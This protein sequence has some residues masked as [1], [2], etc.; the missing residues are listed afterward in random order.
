ML[1]TP[2][3]IQHLQKAVQSLQDTLTSIGQEI[4]QRN[5][6]IYLRSYSLITNFTKAPSQA[7]DVATREPAQPPSSETNPHYYMI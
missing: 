4:V 2:E 3:T 1:L 5:R 6:A 7:N